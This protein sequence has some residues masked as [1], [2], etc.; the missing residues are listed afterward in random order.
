LVLWFKA[1]GFSAYNYIVKSW[2]Q[3]CFQFLLAPILNGESP[4]ILVETHKDRAEG[5][6]KQ[7]VSATSSIPGTYSEPSF[8]VSNVIL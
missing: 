5:Q 2:F 7:I 4:V 6:D 1:P 3:V 8:L